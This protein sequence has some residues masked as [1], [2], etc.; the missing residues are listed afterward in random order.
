MNMLN[1]ETISAAFEELKEYMIIDKG[2]TAM[3]QWNHLHN[4]NNQMAPDLLL[5]EYT[6][7]ESVSA[8]QREA[9]SYN[10][11]KDIFIKN[12]TIPNSNNQI[13]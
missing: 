2:T 13:C 4:P 1:G 11:N 5:R 10:S 8:F 12:K 7:P 6:K 9:W 3:Y